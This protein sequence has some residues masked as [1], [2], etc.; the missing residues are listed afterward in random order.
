MFIFILVRQRPYSQTLA[1]IAL[2]TMGDTMKNCTNLILSLG[3]LVTLFGCG[4][5]KVKRLK[6][7]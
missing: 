2:K 5:S 4:D 1:V 6:T 7:I 3:L